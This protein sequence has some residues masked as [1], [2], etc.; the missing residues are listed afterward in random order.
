[1]VY[2]FEKSNLKS[3]SYAI[4]IGDKAIYWD[5]IGVLNQIDLRRINRFGSQT[6]QLFL[7]NLKNILD[8]LGT[9]RCALI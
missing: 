4:R 6:I 3:T 2:P 8:F 7:S 9:L 1:M 5:G